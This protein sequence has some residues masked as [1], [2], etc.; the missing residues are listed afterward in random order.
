MATRRTRIV[1]ISDTHNQTPQLPAG[2]IL[3]HAGDLTNQ[4]TYSELQ[5]TVDW[6][7]KSQFQIKIVV[8]GN[9]D[10]TCDVP[11]Y[12]EYGG[13][14]HNKRR[15][16][17]QRCLDLLRADPSVVFLSH[18]AKQIRIDHGGGLMSFLKIFGSPY[19]PAHGF[20][21]FGYAPETAPRLWDQIP[22]DSDIVVTHTPAKFHCDECGKRG[23]AGCEIL[24]QTLWRVRPRLFVC[25]HIHEAYGVEAVTWDLSS[26]NLRYKEQSVRRWEDPEPGS[27]K[28]FTVDLSS[29][30]KSL[31]LR[32]D[33]SVGNLISTKQ[34]SGIRGVEVDGT[35]DDANTD[36]QDKCQSI[37]DGPS[38]SKPPFPDFEKAKVPISSTPDSSSTSHD[39][40]RGQG[41]PASSLRSDQEALSGREGRAETCIVNAAYM[42]SNWPHKGGKKFHK[43]VVIDLDLPVVNEK[44]VHQGPHDE[45]A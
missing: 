15:E 11:F 12:Q 21:A 40:T 34:P 6:I 20:W 8:C 1:C 27:K 38:L 24:R 22:L 18:E 3:V 36:E 44:E 14:F 2:H 10:V 25:G 4:G 30:A 16:D 39:G 42:A 45:E 37:P 41:G 28:Q 17:P 31:A 23:T 43:P 26:P 29:R 35:V 19:S 7:R 9:H 13:Y 5:K 32:N 33:G